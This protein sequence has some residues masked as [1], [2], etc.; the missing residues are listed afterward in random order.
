MLRSPTNVRFH[1]AVFGLL[2]A[3]LSRSWPALADA[4]LRDVA[5]VQ[6]AISLDTMAEQLRRAAESK[7]TIYRC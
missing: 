5:N 6:L 7:T 1:A 4:A 2:M 3:H